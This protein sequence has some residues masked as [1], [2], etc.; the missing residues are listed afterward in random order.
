[1]A[2]ERATQLL[3]DICGG[4]VAP[5]VSVESET[6]LPKPN[7][8]TLRRTKLDS[9]LGHHIADADVVEILKRLGMSVES[10]AE[11]WVATAP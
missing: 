9:L 6:D 5:V 3:V 10:C 7:Q 11:S 8:V 1:S 4:E 2:M